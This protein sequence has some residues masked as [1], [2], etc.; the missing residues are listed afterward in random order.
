MSMRLCC[1]WKSIRFLWLWQSQFSENYAIIKW[2]AVL[3]D[4]H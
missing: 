4:S 1:L 2:I 3:T